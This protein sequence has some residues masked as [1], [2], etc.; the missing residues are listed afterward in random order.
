VLGIIDNLLFNPYAGGQF[1][2]G[3]IWALILIFLFGVSRG[4]KVH[5]LN[6]QSVKESSFLSGPGVIGIANHTHRL[7]GVFI[8]SSLSKSHPEDLHLGIESRLADMTML[9]PRSSPGSK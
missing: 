1:G 3:P 8:W 9:K 4:L 6:I 7:Q 2:C 5:G